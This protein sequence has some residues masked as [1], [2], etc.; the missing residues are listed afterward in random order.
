LLSII[1]HASKNMISYLDL[2]VGAM[3]IA[4][5]SGSMI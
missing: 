3:T 4:T 5:D 1:T 2:S